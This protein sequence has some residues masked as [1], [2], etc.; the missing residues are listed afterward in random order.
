M[1]NQDPHVESDDL[2]DVA[3]SATS[4]EPRPI[5]AG[6]LQG[7]SRQVRNGSRPGREHSQVRRRCDI[8]RTVQRHNLALRVY[9]AHPSTAYEISNNALSEETWPDCF[10]REIWTDFATRR[11]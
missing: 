9:N 1:T 7:R 6:S 2:D 10:R 11:S 3:G 4:C 5:L 8:R